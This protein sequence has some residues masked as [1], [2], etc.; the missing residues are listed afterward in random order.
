MRVRFNYGSIS[1]C[2]CKCAGDSVRSLVFV[3]RNRTVSLSGLLSPGQALCSE[4]EASMLLQLG[5][6]TASLTRAG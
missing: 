6:D 1:V 5:G 3:A 4:R 2:V